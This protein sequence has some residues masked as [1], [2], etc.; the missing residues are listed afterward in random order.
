MKPLPSAQP[1]LEQ[2]TRSERAE[3]D[4]LGVK[5]GET[6]TDTCTDT[7][8]RQA[9]IDAI[10]NLTNCTSVRDLYEYTQEHN[11]TDM[12]IGGVNDAIDAVIAVPSIQPEAVIRCKDCKYCKVYDDIP[13]CD[14]L[15]GTFRV[16]EESFCSFGKKENR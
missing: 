4:K 6:C 2:N 15:T 16:K 7:I 8:S 5:M 11:L 1:E 3:S 14:R 10:V 9:A 12:W 13:W